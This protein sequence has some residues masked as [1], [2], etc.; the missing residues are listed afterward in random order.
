M[1][2]ADIE[3]P[4]APVTIDAPMPESTAVSA[5]FAP[6]RKTL[7]VEHIFCRFFEIRAPRTLSITST[8]RKEGIY[9]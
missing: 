2:A 5:K 7:L 1:K 8:L 9:S 3:I 4:F 6:P